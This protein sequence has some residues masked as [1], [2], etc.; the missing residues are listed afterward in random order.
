MKKKNVER[1][2]SIV[3]KLDH[4]NVVKLIR[5]VDTNSQVNIFIII[6]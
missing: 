5:T 4:P 2:I 1:E 3:K 6:I